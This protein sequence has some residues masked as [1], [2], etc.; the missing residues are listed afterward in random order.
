MQKLV[1]ANCAYSIEYDSEKVIKY[2]IND[3]DSLR[4]SN[5]LQ[6]LETGKEKDYNIYLPISGLNV[7]LKTFEAY[8]DKH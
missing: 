4:I 3:L 1:Q 8:F 5:R 6:K 7:D 2:Y